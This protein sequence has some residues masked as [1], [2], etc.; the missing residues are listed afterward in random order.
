MLFNSTASALKLHV[1]K[2]IVTITITADMYLR[3]AKNITATYS[4]S[5]KYLGNRSEVEEAKIRLRSVKINV[6]A[7]PVVVKQNQKVTFTVNLKDVTPN[8]TNKTCLTTGGYLLFKI[9]GK[10][11]TDDKGRQ[12]NVTVNNLQETFTYTI[13]RGTAGIYVSNKT[14]RNYTVTAVYGN[15]MYYMVNHKNTTDYQVERSKININFNSATIT[16]NN[17][18]IKANI[19][20]Y[21]NKLVVGN[22]K[23]CIK[24]NGVTYKEN[25]DYKYFTVT[26]GQID[27]SGIQIDKPDKVN[28]ITIVTG[29]RGAYYASTGTTSNIIKR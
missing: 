10:G 22:N 2:G 14:V 17:L 28:N 4:G 26:N 20:D 9:N 24:I 18:S 27:L 6:T 5:Y 29:D 1:S 7:T 13:P 3:H 25:G 12:V 19:T 23:V 16:G 21:Q 11:I 15:E 8:G